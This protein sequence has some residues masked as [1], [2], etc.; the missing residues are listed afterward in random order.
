MRAHPA[1][2]DNPASWEIKEAV[3]D[4]ATVAAVAVMLT[5]AE[6]VAEIAGAEVEIGAAGRRAD[7]E[8]QCRMK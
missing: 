4:A 8:F 5:A 7:E 2:A 1:T 6:A 3:A